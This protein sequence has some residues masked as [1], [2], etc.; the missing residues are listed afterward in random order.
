MSSLIYL[1]SYLE[2]FIFLASYEEVC[3]PVYKSKSEVDKTFTRL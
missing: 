2:I 3:D 1:D